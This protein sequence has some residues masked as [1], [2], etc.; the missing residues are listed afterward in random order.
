MLLFVIAGIAYPYYRYKDNQATQQEAKKYAAAV[1]S[2]LQEDAAMLAYDPMNTRD[3]YISVTQLRDD[4]LRNEFSSS[5]RKALWRHVEKLV[6]QNSN[7]RT[8]VGTL[9]TGDVGRGWRWTGAVRSVEDSAERPSTGSRRGSSRYS[10]PQA[11][12]SS[13][14]MAQIGK[15]A[16]GE[17][18]P[19]EEF[20]RWD[21]G[22]R[23][24]F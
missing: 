3:G 15:G 24:A 4:V 8:K 9:D 17:A 11:L 20:R 22:S 7:V 2:S 18:R 19:K 6:E 21:S 1:Y 14:P 10:M 12:S 5:R 16:N 23:P 13:P